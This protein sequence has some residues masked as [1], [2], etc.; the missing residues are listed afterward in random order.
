MNLLEKAWSTHLNCFAKST[1]EDVVSSNVPY[2]F[3]LQ[4]ATP[5]QHLPGGQ[6]FN[7]PG[8]QSGAHQ[9]GRGQ[10]PGAFSMSGIARAL[11]EYQ[12]STSSQISHY[13]QQRFLAGTPGGVSPYSQ[14]SINTANFPV[15]PSQYGSVYQYGQVQQSPQTQSAGPSPIHPSYFAGAYFPPQQQQYAY[16]PGQYQQPSQPH[17][18]SFSSYGHG[19]S[20][21][22]GHQPGEIGRPM[23]S[24]YSPSAY[25]SSG[26]SGQYLRPGMPGKRLFYSLY[27]GS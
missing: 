20:P 6:P 10:S 22:Y 19:A 9:L 17:H 26:S 24:G 18:G 23:H 3:Q 13:D 5:Q 14:P 2:E 21:G 27:S 16:Y 25:A 7:V 11:P 1:A 15:H 12:S 8:P 4:G